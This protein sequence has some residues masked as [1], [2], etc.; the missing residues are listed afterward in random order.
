MPRRRDH[1]GPALPPEVERPIPLGEL[2]V[3]RVAL[4]QRPDGGVHQRA[5]RRRPEPGHGEARLPLAE[6][7]V[8][9]RPLLPLARDEVDDL[10]REAVLLHVDPLPVVPRQRQV[11]GLED[12][13]VVVQRLREPLREWRRVRVGLHLHQGEYL[14]RQ[15]LHHP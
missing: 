13:G 15:A 6:G 10:P 8:P 9:L 3:V 12:G 2:V 7:L 11:D 1:Q 14:R 4:Q 5:E